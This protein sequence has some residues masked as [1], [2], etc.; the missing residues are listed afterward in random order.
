MELVDDR[1]IVNLWCK[2]D[3]TWKRP[4]DYKLKTILNSKLKNNL[5]DV[6]IPDNVKVKQYQNNLNRFL[7]TSRK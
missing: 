4:V 1:L 6:S 7:H 5:D 3:V 2:Q